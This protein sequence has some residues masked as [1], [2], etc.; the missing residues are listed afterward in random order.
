[1]GNCRPGEREQLAYYIS[2][3]EGSVSTR[4]GPQTPANRRIAAL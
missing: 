1:M 2:R 4:R 3:R